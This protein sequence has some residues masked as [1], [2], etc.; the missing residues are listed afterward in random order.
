[1]PAF[2]EKYSDAQREAVA[3]AYEDRKIRPYRRVAELAA[4]GELTH[5]GETLEPFTI[6]ESYIA[7]LVRKLRKRRAGE[8]TSQLASAEPRDAIEALR[9]RLVNA[10]DAMLQDLEAKVKRDAGTADPERL[11]QITRAVREAAALPGPNDPKPPAPGARVNGQRDGGETTGGLAGE[12]LKANRTANG[13]AQPAQETAPGHTPPTESEDGR[14]DTPSTDA[15]SAAA[16]RETEQHDGS[17][18]AQ[19]RALAVRH[20]VQLG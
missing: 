16:A 14:A 13:A 5:N 7:D 20:G 17:P 4:A 19:V 8:T 1:M 12:I 11:R 10:A 15:H 2:A 6:P 3:Y 18:G 9:K